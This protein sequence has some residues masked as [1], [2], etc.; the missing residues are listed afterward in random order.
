MPM[1]ES[2]IYSRLTPLF[3][4]VFDD[5]SIVLNPAMTADDVEGWDS[6][7]NAVLIV[8]VESEF[9]IKFKPA[10]MEASRNVGVLVSQIAAKVAA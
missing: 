8:Q 3:H 4:D 1:P 6:F 9:G 10:E 7:K 2:E 5:E